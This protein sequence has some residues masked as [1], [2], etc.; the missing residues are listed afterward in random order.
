MELQVILLI[1]PAQVI[2]RVGQALRDVRKD[3]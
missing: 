3:T 2:A 1:I